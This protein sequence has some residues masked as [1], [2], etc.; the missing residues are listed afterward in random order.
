[1][2][3]GLFIYQQASEQ[4]P[5]AVGIAI[6][7]EATVLEITSTSPESLATQFMEHLQP[8]YDSE[9]RDEIV[10]GQ[11]KYTGSKLTFVKIDGENYPFDRSAIQ[12]PAQG[13]SDEF[14]RRFSDNMPK[15]IELKFAS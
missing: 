9:T 14:Q 1:M 10:D 12:I 13:F 5:E 7:D 3:H 8:G 4:I 11:L 15:G 2:K 6:P